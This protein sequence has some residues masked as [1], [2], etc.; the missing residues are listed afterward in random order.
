[1]RLKEKYQKE[2]VPEMKKIF[3]YKNDLAVP[4]ISF[5]TVNVGLNR[6]KTEKNSSYIE[7]VEKNIISITGQKPKRSL[8]R[9]SIAGFKIRQGLVV[10]LF[11]TLRG[12][13]MY[14][15]LEKLIIAALPRTKDFRG[16]S[17]KSIDQRGNLTIGFKEQTPF[18]EINPEKMPLIHGLEVTITTTAKTKEEGLKLLE[19]LGIP[20]K[21]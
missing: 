20:F 13:K 16:I 19:L 4:R 15:F 6:D 9:K 3:S 1:M 10:G 18:P 17:Q 21:N 12:A 5:I 7:E 2:V 14:D 8:A 11:V